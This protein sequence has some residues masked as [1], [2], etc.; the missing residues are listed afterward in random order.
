MSIPSVNNARVFDSATSYEVPSYDNG[1][2]V[3][4]KNK[5]FKGLLIATD[6]DL[7]IRGCDGQTVTFAVTAGLYP[8]AGT[9]IVEESTTAEISVVLF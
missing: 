7:T 5:F 3:S 8:F 9:A 1:L 2:Y 4:T 6:G